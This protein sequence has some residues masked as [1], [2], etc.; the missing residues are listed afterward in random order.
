[1]VV[2]P[3]PDRKRK[4]SGT[5]VTEEVA[6]WLLLGAMS[7]QATVLDLS[8]GTYQMAGKAT[9][10]IAIVNGENDIFLII[11]PELGYFVANRLELYFALNLLIDETTGNGFG[12]GIGADYFF[13]GEWVAPYIGAGVGVGT[14]QLDDSPVTYSVEE[15]V[16]LSGRGGMLLP[17]SKSVGFDLGLRINGNIA[18]DQSW[19]QVPMG[20]TG[21][22]AFFR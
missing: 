19:I 7:A 21:V 3:R 6:M 4:K 11:N 22:R 13:K 18:S 2:D 12:A 1:M 14:R 15:V 16:T 5:I 20:Y 8:K 10:N 9:A 17:M